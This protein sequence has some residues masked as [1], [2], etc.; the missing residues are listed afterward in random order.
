MISMGTRKENNMAAVS[1]YLPTERQ[2]ELRRVAL[3]LSLDQDKRITL[4]SLVREALEAK[5]PTEIKESKKLAS[6]DA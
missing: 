6:V 1:I 3:Q 5:W 4:S 2:R